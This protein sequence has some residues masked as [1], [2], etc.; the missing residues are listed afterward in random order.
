MVLKQGDAALVAKTSLP[1]FTFLTQ[2]FAYSVVGDYLKSQTEEV[3]VAIYCC[4]WNNFSVNLMKN[5]L[6]VIMRSQQPVSFTAGRYLLVNL[7]TYMMILKTSF[8]YLSML[9]VM[10]D[11]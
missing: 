10:L 6:F 4:N 11:T 8:S 3:A 2:L 7:E 1:L 5:V 9:R